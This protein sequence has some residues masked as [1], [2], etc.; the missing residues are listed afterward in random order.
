M[1]LQPRV[2]FGMPAYNRP[3][4]LPRTLESLLVQT[5]R[6]FALVIVD[7]APGPAVRQ[8]VAEY[9]AGDGRIIYESNA[10]RLGM[11]GNWRK[12]FDR[13]RELFPQSEYFAWV[14]DHDIWHPRW[15]EVLTGVLDREPQVVAAY[16]DS[17]RVYPTERRRAAVFATA[18][19]PRRDRR[20]K[21][22]ATRLTAGNA[23][24]GLFRAQALAQAGVFRP[25]MMP[26]RQVLV[27]LSLLGEFRHVR[28]TLWYREAAGFSY[29]RQRRM[30]FPDRV[31][32]HTYLPANLQ[33]FGI[34][35]WDF[36]I[37]GRGRP[38]VGRTAGAWYSAL[39]LWYTTKRELLRDDS[40]WREGLR[41]TPLGRR[42]LPGGRAVRD[43]RRPVAVSVRGPR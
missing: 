39:Q 10:N 1:S 43:L 13:S 21:A 26:D 22:A 41:R 11:I 28:E 19:D 35:M 8:I 7:D 12:A 20:L 15:L 32:M 29:R 3:D 4:A 42:L 17:V 27:A 6:D 9:A 23:I 40:R 31:P 18:D 38:A 25:V 30:F 16:P 24:Y 34:L 5:N 33:H 36:A 37:R 2:V 14:S